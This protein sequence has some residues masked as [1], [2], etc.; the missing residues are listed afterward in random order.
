M[1]QIKVTEINKEQDSGINHQI[2]HRKFHIGMLFVL[3]ICFLELFGLISM[4]STL[5]LFVTALGG[6]DLNIGLYMTILTLTSVIARPVAGRVIDKL[7]AKFL[8]AF[9]GSVAVIAEIG[10]LLIKSLDPMF[11]LC[12]IIGIAHATLMTA[13]V[14]LLINEAKRPEDRPFMINMSGL[15]VSL[16]S[17][18][19]PATALSILD[20]NGFTALHVVTM[21]ASVTGLVIFAVIF[22]KLK[23][24]KGKS[25]KT[26]KPTGG[27]W[28]FL[29]SAPFLTACFGYMS[30]AVVS[31][32]LMSYL[33]LF[34]KQ[35]GIS[36]VGLFFTIEAVVGL[37]FRWFI[38][39]FMNKLGRKWFL[40]LAYAC[41]GIG[42][43]GLTRLKDSM[44]GLLIPALIYGFGSCSIYT[45]LATQVVENVPAEKQMIAMG[46]FMSNIEIG[47]GVGS[48]IIGLLADSM[49][50][51]QRFALIAIAPVLGMAAVIFGNS[52]KFTGNRKMIDGGKL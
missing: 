14:S 30:F 16:V 41:T 8:F 20:K 3:L 22:K 49:T 50:Y 18:V 43:I 24:T 29:I 45:P 51:Q 40:I 2:R 26:V 28:E 46:L 5:T 17:A 1:Q 47:I 38:P 9:A 11:F 35:Q 7:G 31:G 34:G 4:R 33:P 15:N 36:N 27:S 48:L 42:I 21:I 32:V 37:T 12:I 6:N 23:N 10:H 19:A 52:K 25:E 44:A 13:E 39:Y